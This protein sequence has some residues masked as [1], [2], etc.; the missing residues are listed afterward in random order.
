MKSN[1]EMICE[2]LN[3]C[4]SI[5]S[6]LDVPLDLRSKLNS[7]VDVLETV[8]K[9]IDTIKETSEY[10]RKGMEIEML[11]KNQAYDFIICERLL[12]RFELFCNLYPID[13]YRNISGINILMG[14][15]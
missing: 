6:E 5:M 11:A 12:K 13:K 9:V 14:K 15:R 7:V 2:L 1:I 8:Y 3:K 10:N 4:I